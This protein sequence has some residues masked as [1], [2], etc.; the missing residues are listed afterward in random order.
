ML[1]KHLTPQASPMNLVLSAS[2]QNKSKK[3]SASKNSESSAKKALLKGPSEAYKNLKKSLNDTELEPN[4]SFIQSILNESNVSA[5]H[6]AIPINFESAEVDGGGDNK[7]TSK[8][9]SAKGTEGDLEDKEIPLEELDS[10]IQECE[11]EDIRDI[12]ILTK[13]SI[14]CKKLYEQ[15]SKP[16]FQENN[17]LKSQME[18]LSLEGARRQQEESVEEELYLLNERLTRQ[19]EK[20]EADKHMQMKRDAVFISQSDPVFQMDAFELCFELASM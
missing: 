12:V 16:F 14:E 10:L 5:K 2:D 15:A 18:K 19:R 20:M 6:A 13:Q 9:K 8:N 4:K 7:L 1:Y 3:E 17:S 11:D